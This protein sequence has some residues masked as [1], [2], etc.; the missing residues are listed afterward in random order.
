MCPGVGGEMGRAQEGAGLRRAE[1]ALIWEELGR[2]GAVQRPSS[3]W[4][5]TDLAGWPGP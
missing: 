3:M 5:L 2:G 4:S 1:L